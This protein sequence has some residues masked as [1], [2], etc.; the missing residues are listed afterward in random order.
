ML[1]ARA[2][3]ERVIGPAIE[4]H[5]MTGPPMPESVDEGGLCHALGQAQIAVERQAGIPVT[6]KSARFDEGCRADILVDRR[7]I[8]DIGAVAKIAPAHDAQGPTHLRMSAASWRKRHQGS[9]P[10]ESLSPRRRGRGPMRLRPER[11][12]TVSFRTI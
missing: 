10:R 12:A 5:R 4:V 3:T 7:L 11:L 9:S 6:D 8:V 2:L 1:P